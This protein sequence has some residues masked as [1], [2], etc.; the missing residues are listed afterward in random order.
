MPVSRSPN[1]EM[2][3]SAKRIHSDMVKD[4]TTVPVAVD[5][6]MAKMDKLFDAKLQNVATK[7]DIRGLASKINTLHIDVENLKEENAALKSEIECMK[8]QNRMK[9]ADLNRLI[10]QDKKKKLI[11][12][13]LETT[14]PKVDV[15]TVCKEKLA[16]RDVEVKSA[17]KLFERRGKATVIADFGS[18]D[19]AYKI[20]RNSY[21]LAGT[22]IIVERDL[23]NDKRIKK[24]IMLRIK[25][26]ILT[27]D[28]H[29]KI[30]VRDDLL[31]IENKWFRYNNQNEFVCGSENGKIEI[32]KMY[33]GRL[34][35]LCFNY[36]FMLNVIKNSTASKNS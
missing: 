27:I 26:D 3:N 12:K 19:A 21:K 32:D 23:N 31:K 22:P 2:G 17:T 4:D 7:E 15:Q 16:I 28:S 18:E 14:N 6:L 9:N 8:N 34:S 11:F 35:N 30:F 36:D 1:H 25:K 33:N 24:Q 20:L 5:D 13:G 29:L 10:D